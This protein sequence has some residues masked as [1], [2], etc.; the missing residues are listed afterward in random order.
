MSFAN[1]LPTVSLRPSVLRAAQL[2]LHQS[3]NVHATTSRASTLSTDLFADMGMDK[4]RPVAPE[5]PPRG[6][7]EWTAENPVAPSSRPLPRKD[8]AHPPKYHFHA[9]FSPNN[10]KIFLADDK[11]RPVPKGSWSGG[12][13][14]FKGVNRS[15]QEAG[16]RCAVNA[17]ARIS[18]IV[19]ER[20]PISLAIHL[21]GFGKG[22][23]AV[24][25]IFLTSEG[26]KVRPLVVEVEDRTH[27]KIGGTRAKKA[28]RL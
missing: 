6:L 26:D 18:E 23:Q 14:G 25:Q 11:F 2:C 21:R 22:R 13:C 4:P 9:H 3:R 8:G 19:Q 28:R 12:S 10:T 20:G 7:I 24:E 17:F 5:L 27:I 15:M 16:Y 1:A